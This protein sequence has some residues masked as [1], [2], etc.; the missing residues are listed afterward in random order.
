MP[1]QDKRAGLCEDRKE[2][3]VAWRKVK[4]GS[5]RGAHHTERMGTH[6]KVQLLG[7]TDVRVGICLAAQHA[8]W[9]G[10]SKRSE[11][12]AG[13]AVPEGCPQGPALCLLCWMRGRAGG[14]AGEGGTAGPPVPAGSQSPSRSPLAKEQ[15]GPA[16]R[17][18]GVPAQPRLPAQPQAEP[19]HSSA[20]QRGAAGRDTWLSPGSLKMGAPHVLEHMAH[21]DSER[22]QSSCS[23][24]A[25]LTPLHAP[26]T[27]L[28]E[29]QD[30]GEFTAP[31]P[32]G[33]EPSSRCQPQAAPSS[34][35]SPHLARSH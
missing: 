13:P 1:A 5:L 27:T 15:R 23:G 30:E 2:G 28:R 11:Q 10:E 3:T 26:L 17:G 4:G 8:R 19:Q 14:C 35:P 29:K 12:G 22:L 18:W 7:P 9:R 31:G 25:G 16:R 21:V 20:W 34:L 32:E 6:P 33:W 24:S